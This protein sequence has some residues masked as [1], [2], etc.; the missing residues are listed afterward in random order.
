MSIHI[1]VY[2]T[3]K[4]G[5]G[6]NFYLRHAN[7]I[8]KGKTVDKFRLCIQGLPFLIEG[9]SSDGHRVHVEV[10]EVTSEQLVPID[11]LEGHPDWYKRELVLVE[12]DSGNVMECWIYFA[13]EQYDNYHYHESFSYLS[14]D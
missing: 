9:V 8:G 11:D 13:P 7:Y 14:W 4:R 10:Y 5:F 3:L 6:N 1:A 2:G 12:L